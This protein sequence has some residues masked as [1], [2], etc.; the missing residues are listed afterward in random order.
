MWQCSEGFYDEILGPIAEA[1]SNYNDTN[2]KRGRDMGK[3]RYFPK[4]LHAIAELETD[5]SSTTKLSFVID[6]QALINEYRSRYLSFG[7]DRIVAFAGIARA[8]TNLGSLTYLAGCWAQLLPLSLLW[9]VDRK[10]EATVRREIEGQKV[11]RGGKVTFPIAIREEV[12]QYAPSWSQFSVPIYTHH[13]TYFMLNNDEVYV[14][15]RSLKNDQRVRW[16]DI[17]WLDKQSFQFPQHASDHFPDSGYFAFE[18]LELTLGIPVLPVHVSWPI[19]IGKQFQR[20]R[21]TDLLDAELNWVPEFEY[22]PDD[23]AQ[24]GKGPPR[25]GVLA[26][27]A[28]FQIV[29]IAGKYNIQRRFAG[30]AL[31]P[32]KGAEGGWKRVGAWKLL[33]KVSGVDLTEENIKLVAERW[34]VYDVRGQGWLNERVT[35]V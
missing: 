15:G 9:H 19:Q 13:Q 23:P 27:V 33:V 28:E 18:G 31:V 26:L 32:V 21:Q 14:R 24:A 25:H 2:P 34:R 29:R 8:F 5:M 17:H 11:L 3:L 35:L 16:D 22:Y 10:L 4:C 20:I 12:T 30:L 1:P 6:W 7:K